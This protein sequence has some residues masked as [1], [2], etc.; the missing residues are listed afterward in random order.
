MFFDPDGNWSISVSASLDRGS[1]PYGVLKVLDRNNN[2]VYR[3]IV[4]TTGTGGRD[5]SKSNADT[6]VGEYQILEWRATGSKRYPQNSF[7]PND[8]L[9]LQYMGGPESEGYTRSGI[10]LHGGRDQ[11]K[12][13]KSTHG[14]IRIN[15]NDIQDI[16]I[17]TSQLEENDSSETR[18]TLKVENSLTKEVSYEDRIKIHNLR[19]PLPKL[20]PITVKANIL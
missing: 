10:H 2:V 16:K 20:D 1:H 4:R 18:G 15:D 17:I 5:R 12:E 7:G 14:C 19:I 6:P 9:A 11:S 8:L 13:L 3:T